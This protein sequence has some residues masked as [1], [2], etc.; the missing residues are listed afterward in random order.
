MRFS[1]ICFVLAALVLLSPWSFAQEH[2]SALSPHPV[3]GG[4]LFSCQAA[5]GTQSVYLA[6]EFNDWNIAATPM[7]DD[8][9]DG[10]WTVIFPLSQGRWEYKFVV[11]GGTWVTDPHAHDVNY[12]NFNNGIVYVDQEPPGGTRLRRSDL[13]WAQDAELA[14]HPVEGGVLFSYQAAQG[15]QS[16]YLAG[17]FNGWS[18]TAT[19]MADEDSDGLWRTWYPL[20]PGRSYEYKF[21]VNGTQWVTDPNAPETNASNFNNGVVFVAEPG[22]PYAI[23]AFPTNDSRPEEIAPISGHLRCYGDDVDPGSVRIFLGEM[24]LSYE[25]NHESG[26][27]TAQLSEDLPD[28]DYRLVISARGCASGKSGETRIDF[29]MDR[30]PAVFDS[31]DFFDEAVV[32]E[33]FVRSF[34]DSDGDSIGD[35]NGIIQKLDYLNDGD[36]NTT[37]DL[38]ID[39]IWLMPV[40]QSPSYHGYDV[41]DYYTI[42]EDYGTNDDFF[43][44]CQQAHQRGIRIIFDLVINHCSDQHPNFADALGNPDSPYSEWFKFR[45]PGQMEYD[46][47]FGYRGM[48]ELNF[49]SDLVRDYLLEIARY[50]MD[51]NGDGDFSDGVDG[52]RCD[53]AKGPPHDWWKQLRAEL[54]EVRPDFLLLGEVWD[55]VETIYGYFD[56]EFDMQFDY[57]VYYELLRLL[58]DWEKIP[59][60]DTMEA[61]R[62]KFP[63]QAQLLR[64]LNN[65]DNDRILSALGNDLQRNKLAALVLFTLPGTPMIYYGEEVGMTGVNPPDEAIRMPMDWNLVNEQRSDPESLLNWYKQLISLRSLCPALSARHDRDVA[66]YKGLKA[67]PSQVYVY[68][69][70]AEGVD[71]IMVVIN[72]SDSLIDRYKIQAASSPLPPGRYEITD[73]LNRGPDQECFKLQVG[74]GGVIAGYRPLFQLEP[75]TGYLLKLEPLPEK[76]S[77]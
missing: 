26:Q 72:L 70:Y 63:V 17:E 8:E 59:L 44:L 27:F 60:R 28:L 56:E 33:I 29:T 20:R 9:G 14:P 15:T 23:M 54:K 10:V 50:W 73:L 22:V 7:S 36:P 24:A 55:N 74:S 67:G 40:C 30:E 66:S 12:Q 64:F 6:G 41:T 32:Y 25:Y 45:D 69:R 77:H 39:A 19:P 47:F 16:V 42:D 62:S 48:P 46:A 51:P 49:D 11:D 21:V 34:K 38:G 2:G 5:Q 1:C 71:P 13:P 43:R 52:Y 58:N 76:G 4:I 31:P 75:Q 37:D 61:E 68:L 53:V 65:H 57:P 35:L 3:E 18:T